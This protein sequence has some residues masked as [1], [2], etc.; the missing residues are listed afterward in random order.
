MTLPPPVPVWNEEERLAVLRRMRLLD[1]PPEQAFDDLVRMA[2]ELLDMPIAAVHLIDSDRQW[3]KSEI[4]LGVRDLSRDIAFC[5][6]TIREPGALIVPDAT[7][8]PRFADN[9]LVTGAPGIRFYAGEP[10][11]VD[12]HRLGALC[13]I[14][15]K[16]HAGLDE[17]QRFV[18]KTLAAQVVSQIALR[19]AA[20]ER[21]RA[22]ALT[23]QTL[24]STGQFAIISLDLA[25]CVTG[26]NRGASSVLGWPEADIHGRSITQIF[27]PEDLA[28]DAP[29]QDMA[30][31]LAVG[32]ATGSRWLLRRDGTRIRAN[33]EM[34]PL[35]DD[36][37][38]AIGF[39]L[40]LRDSTRQHQADAALL[41]V[42]ERYRLAARATNDA[43]WDWD[44]RENIVLWNEAMEEA[45]GW[46]PADTGATGDWW[47]DNIH[48]EDRDAVDHSIHAVIDGSGTGWTGEY[49]FRRADG[50]YA[51]VLDRGFVIRDAAGQAVRMIG[52]M[53]DL[54]ERKRAEARL[55]EMNDTLEQRVEERTRS[56]REAEETL[57]QSQKMEAVGQLTGG[58]AHDFNNLLAGIS[59]SLELVESRLAQGRTQGVDAFLGT[60]K[61][62]VKRAAALTHRLL[63]FSRRQTLDPRPTDVNRLVADMEELVRRTVNRSIALEVL[64]T[65]PLWNTLVD[66]NQLE[67]ALLN[68]CINGRDAMPDGGRLRIA[69]ANAALHGAAATALNLA[70]GDYVMLSVEDTG[71]GMTADVAAKAFDPFF[72]TKPLGQGTGLGLSMIYGFV[73]QSGG[74]AEIDTAPGRGTTVRLFLPRAQG[75]AE[76]LMPSPAARSPAAAAAVETVLVVDDEPTVRMVVAEVLTDLG[77]TAIEAA[78]AEAGLSL[79]RSN[80]RIDLLV[81][82]VGLPGDMNGREMAEL[83]REHR[84]DLKVLFI[85]GFAETGILSPDRLQAGMQVMSKPFAIEELAARIRSLIG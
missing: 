7:L 79:L 57:R 40:V 61:N 16:P 19:A 4:G 32:E 30:R 84:A 25:G 53:L 49:R 75:I 1:T 22:Q 55:R 68:L 82:D 78:D 60:A 43:V 34:T 15:T 26:W 64:P 2:A 71:S 51:D 50:S 77:Y 10:L 72:T 62:A 74:A 63:A 58:L 69:T 38:I 6:H 52:A 9:P 41:A 11:D 36:D 66:P 42:N 8:D 33:G 45:Y 3:G 80:A 27:T 18:L 56:L 31:A 23:R 37:G 17:R 76:P 67:N 54:S 81:S 85:T 65:A 14:D 35:R 28:V 47:I 24:N 44:L 29:A 39:V 48:P 59:G 83:A 20:A 13:V 70:D 46:T 21:L 5:A 73:R 12:G